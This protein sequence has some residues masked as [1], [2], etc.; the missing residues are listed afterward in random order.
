MGTPP[1]PGLTAIILEIAR[2]MGWIPVSGEY[3]HLDGATLTVCAADTP[4]RVRWHAAATVS[5]QCGPRLLSRAAYAAL[6][7]GELTTDRTLVHEGQ[8]YLLAD[9]WT[10]E[11]FAAELVPA[12]R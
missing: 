2:R 4:D 11:H 8:R 5:S 3:G 6:R 9:V 12:G 1:S 10:G 7:G